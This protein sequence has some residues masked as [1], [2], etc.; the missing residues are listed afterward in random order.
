[1]PRIATLLALLVLA[2]CA[3]SAV[4]QQRATGEAS[5]LPAAVRSAEGVRR[6]I[7]READAADPRQA[8]EAATSPAGT[9]DGRHVA[10]GADARQIASPQD[11]ASRLPFPSERGKPK[12]KSD[13]GAWPSL[14]SAGASLAVVVGVFLLLAWLLRRSSPSSSRRLPQEVYES[15]GH[16]P[17]AGR[18]AVHLLRCGNKLLL[19]SIAPSGAET[20]TEITD[21]DEVDRLRGHC[22]AAAP[23][24]ASATF[25]QLLGQFGREKVEPGFVDDHVTT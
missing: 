17:L 2:R 6:P 22:A 10:S 5:M 24:S 4:A 12:A 3:S 16:A 11:R 19:V 23:G 25:R 18:Q 21:P 20:L 9:R 14:A 15:L 13:S 1:M 8:G 7:R